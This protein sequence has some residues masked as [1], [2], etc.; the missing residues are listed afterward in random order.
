MLGW[1]SHDSLGLLQLLSLR[2]L[3]G[4]GTDSQDRYEMQM[5]LFISHAA[6]TVRRA[7]LSVRV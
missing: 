2:S 6:I 1:I 7:V 3:E 5:H 4:A